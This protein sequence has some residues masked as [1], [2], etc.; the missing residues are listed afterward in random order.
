M[1]KAKLKQPSA[2]RIDDIPSSAPKD[3]ARL[4]MIRKHVDGR[5]GGLITDRY[6][7]WAHWQEIAN[8]LIPRRYKWLIT[9]NQ[10]TRGSPLNQRIIDSTGS[11]A[12]RICAAGMLSGMTSPNQPWFKQSI[13]DDDLMERPEVKEWLDEVTK[14]MRT[15][16]AGSNFYTAMHTLN[17]D[18]AAFGTGVMLVREDYDDVVRFYNSCAGEYFLANSAR[19]QVDTLYRMFVM[20]TRQVYDE[21]GA[22]NVGVDIRV[23]VE[24]TKGAA[25][26][27]EVI[28]AHAVEPNPEYQE[29]APGPKGAK[30]REIYWQWGSSDHLIMRMRPFFESP[31]VAPRW[32]IVANDAYGRGPGMDALGDLKQLQVEQKRKAQAIDKMVNPPLLADVRLKNEPASMIP[33]GVTYA[34]LSNSNVGFK[35][36]YEVKPEIEEMMEDIKECQNRINEVF[37]RDLF[38]MLEQMEGVQPR[39]QMEIM[40]RK[41][42]KVIQ[43]GPVVERFENEAHQPVLDRVF[44]IMLRAGLLPP[45]PESLKGRHIKTEYLSTFAQ[46][47][48]AALTTSVEQFA[49]FVGR[50]ASANPNVLD[51][52]DWDQLI[53]DYA[54]LMGISPKIIVPIAKV[55]KMRT[56]RAQQAQQEQQAQQSMA[57]VQ[58]AQTLSQTNV[59]GGRNALETMLGG[60]M[61]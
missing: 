24:Q 11:I 43:L 59:G 60:S 7:W 56:A 45:V 51:D 38:M 41:S 5:M 19:M 57:A 36:V 37:F 48:R 50:V 31:I 32:D 42:E 21:F 3:N 55:L 14:R 61:Q 30:F 9:P 35:P 47:Q 44:N 58:G 22:A 34:D 26:T 12:L 6:S 25:L 29:G 13:D 2:S 16:L 4:T 28:V 33:G 40:E 15:V 18:L 17:G 39:N 27:R 8:Y 49:G 46:T 23:A 53:D 1:A 10:A 52:V 54:D 20:T